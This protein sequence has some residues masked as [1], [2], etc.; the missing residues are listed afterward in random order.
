[1]KKKELFIVFGLA[2]LIVVLGIV[3]FALP[4]KTVK[5]ATEKSQVQGVMTI[6]VKLTIDKNGQPGNSRIVN[7]EN[8][9]TALDLLKN[10]SSV[11]TQGE[12][13]NAYVTELNGIK[14]DTTKKEFWAFYVNG[15]LADVGADSYKLKANDQILWKIETF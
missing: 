10:A 7:I 11:K 13:T 4:K 15:K 9:K 8:G 2:F 1:M 12:G 6:P 14:A 5:T 3:Y